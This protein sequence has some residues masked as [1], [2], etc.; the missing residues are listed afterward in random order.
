MNVTARM[1][2]HKTNVTSFRRLGPWAARAA[3]TAAATFALAC[4]GVTLSPWKS[5]FA[6][7]GPLKIPGDVS[8][9]N[10][11][12]QRIRAGEGYYESAAAELRQRGYPT[13]S[14]FNWRTPLPMWLIGKLPDGAGKALIGGLALLLMGAALRA[15]TREAGL[16][17]AGFCALLLFGAVMPVF[18]DDL[19]VMPVLWAGVLIGL[20][21]CAYAGGH[22]RCGVAAGLLALFCRDLAGPY[23]LLAAIWAV[24]E[25]RRAEVCWWVG[26]LAAYGLFF[27]AHAYI[28][29]SLL[30]D[31]ERAH[32]HSWVRFGGLAF[33]LSTVQTN[34]YLLVCPQWLSALYFVAAMLGLAG[35]NSALGR[36][37]AG[38]ICLYT[39][40]FAVIGQ[41]F[42]QYW[43]AMIAPLFCFA[44]ARAPA[45]LCDLW[46]ACRSREAFSHTANV[47]GTFAAGSQ[48]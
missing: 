20:S 32:D 40:G 28:V 14:V 27:A 48:N 23:C 30:G 10:A 22:W 8:L 17:Q 26:G 44:A 31:V 7:R 42:N 46:K 1:S 2:G 9:Y 29:Q 21:I 13:A 12:I 18:L 37:L 24:A 4:V 47:S 3:L 33:V 34:A 43:G 41:P 15:M 45:A 35:W 6:D 16:A 36:R 25:R 19:Y 39:V 11:E 5:G 38:A